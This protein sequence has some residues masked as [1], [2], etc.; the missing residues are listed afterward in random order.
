MDNIKKLEIKID[1]V[2]ELLEARTRH[3]GETSNNF[4]LS[5]TVTGLKEHL[6]ELQTKLR[7]E[8]ESREKEVIE[9]A[10]DE[11][12]EFQGTIPFHLLGELAVHFSD[13]LFYASQHQRIGPRQKGRAPKEIINALDLRL[14]DIAPGSTRIFI[15]GNTA[16][17]LF[18]RS[19]IEDAL[20]DTFALLSSTSFDELTNSV[21]RIGYRS[22]KKLSQFLKDLSSEKLFITLTWN[23]PTKDTLSWAASRERIIEV[24]KSLAALEETAPSQVKVIGKVYTLSLRGYVEIDAQAQIYR[25]RV[26]LSVIEQ[27]KLYRVG[28]VVS[29][30]L[31]KTT[32]FNKATTTERVFYTLEAIATSFEKPENR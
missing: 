27:L 13:A 31:D 16:P 29:A 22:A 26:P 9:L 17:D 30:I 24:I 8:K 14:A 12:P 6:K 11:T 20:K 28:D 15:S 10:V 7:R 21:S 4:A 19:L 23:T 5:L 18:G 3:L 2:N 32:I 1:E 25:A